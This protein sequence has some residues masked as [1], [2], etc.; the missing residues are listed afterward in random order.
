MC[1]EHQQRDLNCKVVYTNQ[2]ANQTQNTTTASSTPRA[3][4]GL[5]AGW[6]CGVM[7]GG[8]AAK[9]RGLYLFTNRLPG[10]QAR[11]LRDSPN[12]GNMTN[13]RPLIPRV[14]FLYRYRCGFR[15]LQI[16]LYGVLVVWDDGVQNRTC[17]IILAVC[18][19]ICYY[20]PSWHQTDS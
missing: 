8:N 17:L 10:C 11:A 16:H 6:V 20:A 15:C 3:V 18:I 7:R 4:D 5:A 9:F 19:Y 13:A 1:D 14:Y 2:P 12:R